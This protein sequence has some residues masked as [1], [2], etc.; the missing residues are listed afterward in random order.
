MGQNSAKGK[1]QHNI[2]KVLITSASKKISLIKSVKNASAKINTFILVIAGDVDEHCLAKFVADDFWM[3]PATVDIELMAILNGCIERGIDIVIPTRNSELG[4]WTR[5]IDKFMQKDIRII[6]S[7]KFTIEICLDKIA[8]AEYG[9]RNGLPFIPASLNPDDFDNMPLVVKERYGVG[10]QNLGINLNKDKARAHARSLQNPI[11]Q[12]FIA[13]TEISVDAWLDLNHH[14][15]GIV[16]RTRDRI[17]HGESQVS[18]T[19][20]NKA[21]ESIMVKVFEM[22]RLRGP[23]VLQAIIDD[24][25]NPNII[26]C[27][28]RFGGASTTSIA[29]GL[30]MWYWTLLEASGTDIAEYS[31]QRIMGEVRQIRIPQDIYEYDIDF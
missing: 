31:F 12:P 25:G 6:V 19:F 22:L 14:V 7:P 4:F 13:G 2:K 10:S 20:R 11:F 29:A 16:L 24:Q 18:T 3:M 17:V 23:A 26:E 1:Q 15:K 21:I 27:N 30:D 5:N 28:P 8:F 9:A